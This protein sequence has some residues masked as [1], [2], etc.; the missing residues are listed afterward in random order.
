MEN[1]IQIFNSSAFGEIRVA[2]TGNDPLFCASDVC[3]SLGYSNVSKAISDHVDT[4]DRYNESL[5]RG[6]NMLFINESGLWSLV[7]RSNL[8][9]A[10]EYKKWITSEVLPSIRKHGVYMTDNTIER[11]LTSPDFLILLATELKNEKTKSS[12]LEEQ[13]KAAQPK[14][15]F[16][17]AVATSQRSCLIGELAKILQQNGIKI[18]QNRMFEWLRNNR[19]LCKHGEYYNQPTQHAM[20][21]GL[22]E[23]KKTTITK[24]DGAVLVSTTPKVTGK[25][26]IYF[27]NKFLNVRQDIS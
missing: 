21:L 6:G 7:L 8:P 25:G 20:E 10:K 1:D 26:Q 22:F 16:A 13:N 4:E 9:K 19:Y 3:K 15:L 18:G 27:V 24:P 2:G 5:E 14:V 11:A 23:I 17:D 12:V